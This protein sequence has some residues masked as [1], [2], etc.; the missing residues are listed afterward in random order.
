MSYG[1]TST[2]LKDRLQTDD[3]EAVSQFLPPKE[4]FYLSKYCVV[5]YYPE[6]SLTYTNIQDNK[7]ENNKF[8]PSELVTF[9]ILITIKNYHSINYE[10]Q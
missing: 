9:K 10:E 6:I 5:C 3:L 1:N 2:K 4:H 7:E 8:I